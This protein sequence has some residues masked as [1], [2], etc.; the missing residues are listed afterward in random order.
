M[1]NNVE[2]SKKSG[3]D[4]RLYGKQHTKVLYQYYS[5]IKDR[6]RFTRHKTILDNEKQEKKKENNKDKLG[7]VNHFDKQQND[8]EFKDLLKSYAHYKEED[9]KLPTIEDAVEQDKQETQKRWYSIFF[10][11]IRANDPWKFWWDIVILVFAIFNSLTI[12]LTLTFEEINK[13]LSENTFYNTV[14]Y[15]SVFFFLLDIFI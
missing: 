11:T 14:N 6:Y 2:F 5:K 1:F 8:P 9:Y 10:I 7:G 13:Q 3:N 15:A 12:P 4:R